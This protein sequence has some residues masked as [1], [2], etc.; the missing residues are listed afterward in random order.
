MIT[1]EVR[2]DV[3]CGADRACLQLERLATFSDIPRRT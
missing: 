1:F 2:E 3:V